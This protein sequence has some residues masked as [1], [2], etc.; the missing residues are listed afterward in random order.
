[1]VVRISLLTKIILTN[2]S[3]SGQSISHRSFS[4]LQNTKPYHRSVLLNVKGHTFRIYLYLHR[5]DDESIHTK[6]NFSEIQK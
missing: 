6:C 5:S 3:E 2:L 4:Y 1:M